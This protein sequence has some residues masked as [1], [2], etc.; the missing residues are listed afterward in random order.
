[1]G[2]TQSLSDPCVLHNY[3]EG[4]KSSIIV[5]VD[6][7]LILAANYE[8]TMIII[9]QLKA[10]YGDLTHCLPNDHGEVDYLNIQ[11]RQ[12]EDGIYLHQTT[13]ANKLFEDLNYTPAQVCDRDLPYQGNLFDV[14]HDSPLL[15]KKEQATY[16]TIIGKLLYTSTKTRI[17]L[18]L[19]I[20]FLAS[21]TVHA[22]QQDMRKLYD[23][24]DWLYYNRDGGLL[25]EHHPE[26]DM[27]IYTWADASDNCHSDARGHTGIYMSIGKTHGSPVMYI[28]K[29]QNLVTKSSTESELIAVYLAIPHAQWA[30]EALTEWGYDQQHAILFQDNISTI[31]IS[32]RGNKPFSK[33]GHINRRYM[34]AQQ[35]IEDGT[36]V[37]PHCPTDKMLPDPLTKTLSIKTSISHYRKM[38]GI[39]PIQLQQTPMTN[40]ELKVFLTLFETT[41]FL[42]AY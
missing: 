33:S 35:H 27:Q 6:D 13:Y 10:K 31:V 24:L 23:T 34:I 21:R 25:I 11:I 1:M 42:N 17:V 18:A 29:K 7:L 36:L 41:D 38:S 28:S 12:T 40:N 37:M 4:K 19:P 30:R 2:F 26:D 20:A 14:D 39:E 3:E 9:G 22:N 8:Q 16:R 5:Y 32:H 15:D